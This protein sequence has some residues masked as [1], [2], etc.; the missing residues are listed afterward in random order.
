MWSMPHNLYWI[1][2]QGT[3]SPSRLVGHTRWRGVKNCPWKTATS[4]V[5]SE[6]SYPLESYK[7]DNLMEIQTVKIEKPEDTNFILGQSHFIKTVEDL[8]EILVQAVPG[9]KFGLAF[10]EASGL[11]LV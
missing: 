10:C 4:Y 9:C 5:C 11:A 6:G 3:A 7:G 2:V 1:V 8:H